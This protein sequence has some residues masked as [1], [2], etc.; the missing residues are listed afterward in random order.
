MAFGAQGSV[1][2][3]RLVTGFEADPSGTEFTFKMREGVP[4]H[5]NWGEVTAEDFK[6]S[7]DNEIQEGSIHS[8]IA[9]ARSVGAQIEVLDKYTFKATIDRPNSFFFGAYFDNSGGAS[10]KVFSKRRYETLGEEAAT[11]D[12][13]GGTGPFRFEKWEQGDEAVLQAVS[14]HYRTT[15][16]FQTV[17]I[18]EIKE[19]ATQLA[20]LETGEIDVAMIPPTAVDR[21]RSKGLDVRPFGVPGV[22]RMYAQG[23]FCMPTT[24]DGEPVTPYPRPAYD[25]SKPWI[26]DC[27]DPESMANAA[28]VRRAVAMSI[29]RQSIVDNIL[30]GFGRATYLPEV[31][32]PTLDRIMQDKWI[33]PYDIERATEML[34]E[35]GYPDGFEALVYITTGSHPLEVEMGQ[36]VAQMMS[37]IG[38]DVSTQVLTYS[39]ARPA[40]VAR[41]R[42]DW[43]F[44]SSGSGT[45]EPPELIMLRRNPENAF[46][47]GFELREP[48]AIM[49]EL[50]VARTLEEADEIRERLFDWYDENQPIIQILLADVIIAVNPDKIGEWPMSK[51][52]GR[53]GDFENAERIGR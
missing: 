47:P 40:V 16:Q 26:G 9:M 39:G 44:R 20:A 4:F 22:Q 35:A 48:L 42:N 2:E 23:M 46:N 52:H 25:P 43:W 51:G 19:A 27:D 41:E 53:I 12:L 18:V 8:S 5:G 10:T 13:S 17:Q 33:I 50:D 28:K 1:L 15:P 24:L 45:A 29:D 37:D 31:T 6:W 3:P 38:I 11:V 49:R 34:A 36:A 7:F 14:G 32:P 21:I 30:G